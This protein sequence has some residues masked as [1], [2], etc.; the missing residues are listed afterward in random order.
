MP[1]DYVLQAHPPNFLD[2]GSHFVDIAIH[3]VREGHEGIPGE[4]DAV[5]LYQNGDSVRAM[6]GGWHDGQVL[7]SNAQGQHSLVE[8]QVRQDNFYL[9]ES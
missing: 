6:A 9:A 7:F 1:L 3:Y 5:F 4:Q 2:G 8:G